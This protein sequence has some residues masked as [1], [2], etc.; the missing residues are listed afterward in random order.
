MKACVYIPTV[1]VNR[2]EQNSELFLGLS[3]MLNSRDDTIKVWSLMQVPGF[4]E[5]LGLKKVNGEF[6]A[7]DVAEKL[8]F[9]N[10]IE[11]NLSTKYIAEENG[12]IVDE[13][14]KTYSILE[15]VVKAA[16]QFN[17]TSK[18]NNAIISK[19]ENGFVINVLS[20]N[21]SEDSAKNQLFANELNNKLLTILNQ[22]GFDLN[23]VKGLQQ[24][25]IFDPLN[26]TEN[27]NKLITIIKIAEGKL[28]EEAFPEE[29]S[30]LIIA[31]L[32]NYPLIRRALESLTD[33]EV[34][35]ILGDQ[36]EQYEREYKGN[37]NTLKEEAL[38]K[39]LA[40]SLKV[41]FQNDNNG[42]L[43]RLWNFIKSIF[44][45]GSV[46]SI[47]NAK[48]ESQIAVD[49]VAKTLLGDDYN[50][51]PID[52][53]DI[54]AADRL[55]QLSENAETKLEKFA[56]EIQKTMALLMK[57]K[58]SLT[59]Q[60]TLT[61]E[62]KETLKKID[63][64]INNK[65]YVDSCNTFLQSAL[66]DV[67]EYKRLITK[68]KSANLQ[69]DPGAVRTLSNIIIN[70]R[71]YTET[72][73]D[74]IDELST[75]DINYEDLDITEQSGIEI[76]K[77]AKEV[78]GIQDSIKGLVK[79]LTVDVLKE[80]LKPYWKDKQ[81]D[82][83]FIKNQV[84]T[85][86]TL[87][88][89]GFND[90][91][92]A[93][94]LVNALSES[95]DI[96][97]S[98]MAKIAIHQQDLR[99]EIMLSD[100]QYIRECETKLRNAGYKN[101]FMYE[102]DKNG[103]PTGWIISNR[104][105]RKFE[106]DKKAYKESLDQNKKLS[107]RAKL[108]MLQKWEYEHTTVIQR[109][110][111][112]ETFNITVPN[113]NY[114][115]SDSE[116][117]LNKLNAAQKEYYDSMM[118]LKAARE[119]SIPEYKQNIYRAVQIRND[120]VES[121]S[122][123]SANPKDLF[124]RCVEKLKDNFV[125]REDDTQY[126]QLDAR[127]QQ[128][129]QVPVFYVN[130]LEDMS[131]LSTDFGGSMRAFSATMLNYSMMNDILPQMELL[132]YTIQNRK[133][134]ITNGGNIVK[135]VTKVFGKEYE[136]YAEKLGKELKI[137]K[138]ADLLMDKFFYGITKKDE[139][140]IGNTKIDTAKFFDFIKSY[141]STVGMGLNVFSGISNLTMGGAQMLIEAVGGENFKLKDLAK[142]HLLYDK[143]IFG[144]LAEINAVK[145]ENKLSL[146]MDKFD[147][148]ESFY[149][150]I[151]HKA[152]YKNGTL[153]AASEL[154]MMIF[155]EIGEH[156]L[157][158]V[159]MLAILN[160]TKVKLDGKEISLYDALEVSK[161]DEVNG[162]KVPSAAH[163]QLRKGVTKLDGSE[164]T[165][166][167]FIRIKRQ[168]SRANRRMHGAYSEAYKGAI[169]QK[170]LGRLAMQF[171]QWMPAFYS[172]RFGQRYYDVELDDIEEGFYVTAFK[173]TTS[174][175]KEIK[176]MKFDFATNWK[177][178]TPHQ[179]AN[180]RKFFTELSLFVILALSITLLGSAKDKESTWAERM[181]RYQLLRLRLEVGAGFPLHPD[182]V[183]NIWTMLQS[184]A[185]AIKSCNNVTDLLKFWNMWNEIETGRYKGYSRYHKDFIEA[186][187]LYGNVRKAMDLKGEDYMF[188]IFNNY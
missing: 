34:K 36:Y 40:Q 128:K 129:K 1:K 156:R 32:K 167:D 114:L 116:N 69:S 26:A 169:H 24:N 35:N 57:E 55:F 50:K 107:A 91:T 53:D 2:V 49:K 138:A 48:T 5:S 92:F 46:Q 31:G 72:Y 23:I 39:M 58:T 17:E 120:F 159:A 170:A 8:D 93:D 89:E 90:I 144:C 33:D 172:N 59:N 109:N 30:H 85:I 157:H 43:Q 25:G 71:K 73:S 117:P 76:S 98:I 187:P 66:K 14:L 103:K 63:E 179:K 186:M 119:S 173:F 139:H 175:M 176:Q 154:N 148:L 163:L 61:P 20:K 99:D 123:S 54:L 143:D 112:G 15:D 68:L 113:D 121:L 105:T 88:N 44:S 79:Q 165:T 106:E 177:N 134:K 78:R 174:M 65:R 6:L 183:D 81:I 101:D 133:V 162:Q 185:A 70:M 152:F 56:K 60:G 37:K 62:Q 140:T 166:E 28:G 188:N 7:K 118:N 45:K 41:N 151:K 110:F 160:A 126:G 178:L 115:Y 95:S 83:K 4:G 87:L 84:V 142:A 82:T 127:G 19:G 184:P 22:M 111:N 21:L 131:Q 27:A 74:I 86:D 67:E 108:T 3:K 80:F 9:K 12:F 29:F 124:N 51:L 16:Q 94:S 52:K 182:F 130:P 122:N 47:E 102:L 100:D 38:G 10:T 181:A 132:N 161:E 141:T 136:Q 145:R 18:N 158:N 96:L 171:R 153:R 125:R 77:A 146:L 11:Q 155:N 150:N 42:F 97:L 104:N 180:M 64:Q 164:F 75:L 168:I 149:D 13:K 135:S 137:G 147:A